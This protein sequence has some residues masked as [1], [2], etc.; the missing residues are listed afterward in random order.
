MWN[1]EIL[2]FVLKFCCWIQIVGGARYVQLVHAL[3]GLHSGPLSELFFEL[4]SP[5]QRCIPA[6][7]RRARV[8]ELQD[9]CFTHCSRWKLNCRNFST[10]TSLWFA[11]VR[12]K[13]SARVRVF[14]NNSGF[15][16]KHA[17][18]MW[19]GRL[20]KKIR[21]CSAPASVFQPLINFRWKLDT[22][23]QL[24]QV[25]FTVSKMTFH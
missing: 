12:E 15:P 20:W 19:N 10:I 5:R 16:S 24:R 1:S 6:C 7:L 9:S 22:T 2:C 13:P 21:W 4:P 23:F 25:P 11:C 3:R 14:K 18:M 8:S 17:E